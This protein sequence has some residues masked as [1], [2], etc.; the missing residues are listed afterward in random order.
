MSIPLASLMFVLLLAVSVAHL[1]WTIGQTWP[2]C[3]EKLLA[4]TVVGLRDIKRMPP[5]LASFAVALATLVTG[6]LAL[7]L[8][9]HDSGGL[10]L[11]LLGLPL[12][13]VFLGRGILGYTVWWA[14]KTPQPN[15]RLNDR[16]VYSPLCLL[17]GAGFLALVIMRLL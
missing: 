15:F 3:D 7:S 14:D 11:T 17:L 2:I 5:R 10:L 8:A 1:L 9:D 4:Q 16:R 6:I 13:A 12:A